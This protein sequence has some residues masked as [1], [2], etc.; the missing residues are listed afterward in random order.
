MTRVVPK[1]QWG[2]YMWGYIHSMALIDD[3]FDDLDLVRDKVGKVLEMFKVVPALM[4]CELCSRHFAEWLAATNADSMAAP[5]QLF[6]STV[7]LHNKVNLAMGKP[8]IDYDDALEVWGC[9]T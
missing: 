2:P 9:R 1:Q 6:Y 5:L 4:P 7:D 8:I 3:V